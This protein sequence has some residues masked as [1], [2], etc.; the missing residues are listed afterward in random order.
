M[1]R[2]TTTLPWSDY[3]ILLAL[4]RHQREYLPSEVNNYA[5]ADC[6]Q[7]VKSAARLR[8]MD[9]AMEAMHVGWGS[10]DSVS[11]RSTSWLKVMVTIAAKA[12]DLV[13]QQ[14]HQG[15]GAIFGQYLDR[16]LP[17]YWQINRSTNQN[18]HSEIK[19]QM[20]DPSMQM[21]APLCKWRP[22]M[23]IGAPL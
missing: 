19:M 9:A 2:S 11:D 8:L 10:Q 22:S 6:T 20:G 4:R 23:Q 14:L 13:C 15:V 3:D 17:R 1:R 5:H 12:S 16:N 21:G 18:G 7:E